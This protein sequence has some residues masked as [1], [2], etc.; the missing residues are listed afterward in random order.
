MKK[1]VLIIV[2][3]FSQTGLL[4]ASPYAHLDDIEQRGPKKFL[5]EKILRGANTITYCIA[6]PEGPAEFITEDQLNVQIRAAIR[7]WTYGIALRVKTA[8]REK[9]FD[10]ALKT[11]EKSFKLERLRS[12]NMQAYPEFVRLFPDYKH[13]TAEA[14]ISF[15]ISDS[16]APEGMED[17]YGS[18]TAEHN[19]IITMTRAH[20]NIMEPYFSDLTAEEKENVKEVSAIFRKAAAGAKYTA[21]EQN[22]LWQATGFRETLTAFTVLAHELGHAFTLADQYTDISIKEINSALIKEDKLMY[23]GQPIKTDLMHASVTPGTGLMQYM[24]HMSCDEVDGILAY[25]DKFDK[26]YF[27]R[28]HFFKSFCPHQTYY[29]NGIPV[30]KQETIRSL[31]TDGTSAHMYILRPSTSENKTYRLVTA[32]KNYKIN[33]VILKA[34]Q[35]EGVDLSQFNTESNKT[36]DYFSDGI[37]SYTDDCLGTWDEYIKIGQVAGVLSKRWSIDGRVTSS[38]FKIISTDIVDRHIRDFDVYKEAYI[39]QEKA[40]LKEDLKNMLFK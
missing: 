15:I 2:V 27:G 31:V 28:D 40:R 30:L 10:H 5:L 16:F 7:E 36:L 13:N 34:L 38:E 32:R 24:R 9:E 25:I 39:K 33:S 26:K 11:L 18:F 29:K 17:V 37:M 6:L 1:I 35:S 14:D 12:C 3:L 21:R 20:A 22:A 19:P 4:L 8:G 23:Y